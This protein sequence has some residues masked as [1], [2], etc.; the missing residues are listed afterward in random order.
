M[1]WLCL[2]LFVAAIVFAK[3][4]FGECEPCLDAQIDDI[5]ERNEEAE[6]ALHKADPEIEDLERRLSQREHERAMEKIEMSEEE[7]YAIPQRESEK[8][9]SRTR[10][11]GENESGDASEVGIGDRSEETPRAREETHQSDE[12][13]EIPRYPLTT[14]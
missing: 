8:E 13:E 7:L 12:D 9:V 14:D 5:V 10:E 4:A 1:K 2:V 6:L 3:V 11:A